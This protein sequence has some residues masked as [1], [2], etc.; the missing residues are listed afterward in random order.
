MK[1]RIFAMLLAASMFVAMM[2]VSA[3]ASCNHA[4]LKAYCS[5]RTVGGFESPGQ[6]HETKLH[7]ICEYGVQRAYSH[8]RCTVCSFIYA[9]DVTHECKQRHTACSGIVSVCNL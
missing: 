4:E 6:Y 1:K 3:S 5:N 8:F 2:P 9:S 7:G